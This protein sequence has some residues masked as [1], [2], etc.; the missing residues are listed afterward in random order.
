MTGPSAAHLPSILCIKILSDWHIGTGTGRHGGIDRLVARD[1][2]DLPYIP[3]STLRSLWR[4]SAERLAFG[5]DAGD[6]TGA[7]STLVGQ[8]FGSQPAGP[9][10]HS[11]ESP[12]RGR[13]FI[14]DARLTD[15]IANLATTGA[16]ATEVRDALTFVKFGVAIDLAT[17]TAKDDHLRFE[18][19]AISGLLLSSP[20][21]LDVLATEFEAIRW[22]L[23]GAACLIERVGAKRRRGL[24]ACE[25]RFLSAGEQTD[26]KTLR[27][28]A[29]SKLRP[30]T[31]P[32]ANVPYVTVLPSTDATSTFYAAIGASWQ[33][34]PITLTLT[35]PL[36]VAEDVQ[37]NVITTQD[38]IPGSYLL[39]IVS[40]AARQASIEKFDERIAIGDL[41]V[42]PATIDI[43]GGRGLPIPQSWS[44]LKDGSSDDQFKV[45]NLLL[46]DDPVAGPQLKALRKGYV[47]A[48]VDGRVA[49][50]SSLH[51]ALRTHNVIDDAVQTPTEDVGGVFSYEAIEP[52]QVFRSV[53]LLRGSVAE[54]QS[55]EKE[56]VSLQSV[57]LGRAKQ[58]G[59]GEAGI[60]ISGPCREI[61]AQPQTNELFVWLETDAVLAG[62]DLASAAD[63]AALARAIEDAVDVNR[64]A[65]KIFDLDKSRAN[66]R[67]RR[68]QSW[69]AQWGMPRPS[70]TVI[71]AGSVAR[72]TFLA[73]ETIGQGALDLL[74]TEG[75]GQRRA[76]GFGA[77]RLNDPLLTGNPTV[78]KVSPKSS[79]IAPQRAPFEDEAPVLKVLCERAWKR[80]I[81]A[82]AEA[83]MSDPAERKAHLCFAETGGRPGMS[84]LGTL[85]SLLPQLE[86]QADNRIVKWACRKMAKS[87]DEGRGDV[88]WLEKIKNV[89][90]P[91][92][93]IWQILDLAE[94]SKSPPVSPG[95][96][97]TKM[98]DDQWTFAVS[99]TLLIAMHH[100]KRAGEKT[101]KDRA[102]GVEQPQQTG[103][104]Q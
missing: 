42:L 87:R 20:V 49:L 69:Q 24:G 31:R 72:L 63:I 73:G 35:S 26:S 1:A 77:L 65:K 7:W 85:R 9:D 3:A 79:G 100:H 47:A 14:S 62:D 81:L 94:D 4:D 15:G 54:K 60:S 16:N 89:S 44:A 104:A 57:R 68:V 25:V 5:L 30:L 46:N 82:R 90:T 37:G 43:E 32:G 86:Q 98:R 91:N 92:G 71:Q 2:Q 33:Q 29:A 75:I 58:A 102:A 93:C 95:T 8:I 23:V 27:K 83:V 99:S 21:R 70:L 80:R 76:E 103:G 61:V 52:G 53:V 50:R 66:L 10:K 88:G 17:G 13:I 64:P 45:V 74:A 38:H 56:L 101:A 11:Q 39:P 6:E 40:A 48:Q 34:I 41:R 12:V 59:Y 96:T 19:V 97:P 22:F 36:V 67:S 84:Q 28:N 18:E 51:T 55:L 78:K